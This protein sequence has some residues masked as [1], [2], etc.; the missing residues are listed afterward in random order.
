M[1]NKLN[2][3]AVLGLS[4]SIISLLLSSVMQYL[5]LLLIG[6]EIRHAL[7]AVGQRAAF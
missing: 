6:D 1:Q 2:Y 3:S 5:R 7:S 4:V